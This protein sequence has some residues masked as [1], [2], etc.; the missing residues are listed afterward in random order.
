M[1]KTLGTI[2]VL[3]SM[4][5][6]GCLENKTQEEELKTWLMPKPAKN[7]E[8][9]VHPYSSMDTLKYGYT[10]LTDIDNDGKWDSAEKV[11]GSYTPKFYNGKDYG[12]I[13]KTYELFFREG[14]GSSQSVD[15]STT[16]NYVDNKFFKLL[17]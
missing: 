8:L 15:T 2:A 16:I 17:E 4:L 14:Y 5:F 1:K 9:V 6:T 12:K 3:S 11:K 7:Q 13:K 10:L